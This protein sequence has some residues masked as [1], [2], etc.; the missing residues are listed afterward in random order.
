[1]D[2]GVRALVIVN[3]IY[4]VAR[5]DIS[6]QSVFDCYFTVVIIIVVII[7]IIIVI[8]IVVIFVEVVPTAFMDDVIIARTAFDH[9]IIITIAVDSVVA[10]TR[11]N[12]NV[13][14]GIIIV[15]EINPTVTVDAIITVAAIDA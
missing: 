15:V 12:V 8:V 9:C 2:L 1:M 11:V 14:I 10:V 7:A 13:R 3:S 6:I 5:T 4:A